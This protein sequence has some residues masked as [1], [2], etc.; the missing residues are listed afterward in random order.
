MRDG[1]GQANMSR[2]DVVQQRPDV[3]TGT[4]ALT[5]ANGSISTP[6]LKNNTGT[7]LGN[8]TNVTVNVYNQSTGAL[9]ARK[10]GLTSD[11]AGV[12]TFTDAAIIVGT[13]YAYEIV[14]PSNGRRLPTGT[15]TFLKRARPKPQ[16]TAVF[17]E[18]GGKTTLAATVLYP[19]P[20]V[21]DAV[22]K[23]GME[24]G[25]AKTYDKLAELLVAGEVRLME[26]A[27]MDS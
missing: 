8:L 24:H 12:V 7:L 15:A 17:V 26:T 21:R 1:E 6:P 9:V 2:P 20:E 16:V 23:S 3:R 22:I 14:T 10:A 18:Q 13:V 11:S 19:T 27:G 4:L 5:G 25:A